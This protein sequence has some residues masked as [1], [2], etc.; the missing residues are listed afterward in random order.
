MSLGDFFPENLR[1]GYANRN[2]KV[3]TVLR[4]HVNDTKPP[5]IKRFVI[6]GETKD[7]ITLAIVWINSKINLNVNRSKELQDL[8]IKLTWSDERPYL[9]K[10]S[11]VN[12]SLI[13]EKSKSEFEKF[14]QD[15]PSKIIGELSSK[16]L[17]IVLNKLRSA[18]TIKPKVKKKF[19]LN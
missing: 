1:K 17:Q 11:F 16:D 8:Q 4:L 19:G 9:E 18:P 6:V 2:L 14:I 3:G 12:C 7:Q 10:D 15:D 5:K 13:I